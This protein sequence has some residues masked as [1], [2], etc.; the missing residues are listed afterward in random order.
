MTLL[1]LGSLNLDRTIYV[2]RLPE[3]GET[4][5]G[6]REA[7]SLGGKGFNQA[8]TAARQGATVHMVGCVGDDTG[9]RR[10]VATLQREG[11]DTGY[12]THHG[13]APTG[14]AHVLVDADGANSIVSIAG[15]NGAVSF[16][17]AALEGIDL[18]LA[19]LEVPVPVVVAAFR[20]AKAAG[21]QT[22]LN[23]SPVPSGLESDELL[24][25][26]DWLVANEHEAALLGEVAFAGTAVV[27]RGDR[28]AVLLRPGRPDRRV[29]AL[30]VPVV[31]TTGA[32]DAFCGALAAGLLARVGPEEALWRASAAGAHAVT[33]EGAL[34]SLPTAAQ[35]RETLSGSDA[36]R[37]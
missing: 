28:G 23:P 6:D 33:V 24:S 7:V 27:T 36:W 4:V 21:V 37:R 15:A 22:M 32:G 14:R 26:T 34:P 18:V 35:V 12:V 3:P 1:V 11:V 2:E 25:L 19:Q 8:V 13:E 30:T 17:S 10:L 31:D 9:G 16:P 20:A 5:R 29:P